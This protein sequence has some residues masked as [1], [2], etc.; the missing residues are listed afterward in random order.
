[1]A[2]EKQ[3]AIEDALGAD[4]PTYYAN[5]LAVGISPYDLSMIFGLRVRQEGQPVARVIMSLEHALVMI[6]VLRRS[7]REH[8]RGTGV[9]PRVPDDVMRDLQL[10]EEEPLW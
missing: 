6:M 10:N 5:T 8:V 9:T 2:D 7:L 1:M 4:V 3:K